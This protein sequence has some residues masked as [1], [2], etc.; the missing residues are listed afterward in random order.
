MKL[1]KVGQSCAWSQNDLEFFVNFSYFWGY[2]EITKILQNVLVSSELYE[3]NQNL[4]I[5][6]FP[7]TTTTTGRC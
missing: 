5:L 6:T 3:L 2:P 4:I 1:V 7:L